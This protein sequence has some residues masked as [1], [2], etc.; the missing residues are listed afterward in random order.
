[1][2]YLLTAT[3]FICV[4]CAEASVEKGSQ[5]GTITI[6]QFGAPKIKEPETTQLKS[7]SQTARR[8]LPV[9]R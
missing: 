4:F 5:P 1:M 2:K 9:K 8:L 7:S 6:T 3:A